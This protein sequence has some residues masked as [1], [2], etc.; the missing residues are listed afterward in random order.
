MMTITVK[1]Y[2]NVEKIIGKKLDKFVLKEPQ[3]L[4]DILKQNLKKQNLEQLANCSL[5]ITKNGESCDDLEVIV[6]DKDVF[7]LCPAIY[8]G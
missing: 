3:T 6:S 4:K 7:C 1:Y 8:G 2:L 5:I